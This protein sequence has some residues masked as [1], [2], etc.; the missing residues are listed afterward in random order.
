MKL[1]ENWKTILVKAWSMRFMALSAVCG[2]AAFAIGLLP[3][4]ITPTLGRILLLAGLSAVFNL[5]AMWSR[6]VAQKGLE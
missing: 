5:L 1:Y 6:L 2:G 4:F 3:T